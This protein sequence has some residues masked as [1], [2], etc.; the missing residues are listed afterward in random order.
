MTKRRPR[1][2]GPH[3]QP[4]V[5]RYSEGNPVRSMRWPPNT[6]AVLGDLQVQHHHK[7]KVNRIAKVAVEWGLAFLETLSPQLRSR[8][9]GVKG[10]RP[11]TFEEQQRLRVELE[12]K[13]GN[14]AGTFRLNDR[15]AFALP[16]PAK[17]LIRQEAQRSHVSMSVIA[18]RRIILQEAT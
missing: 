17:Q 18:R 3:P 10:E 15:L 8:I 9:L 14:L 1:A 12:T 4:N 13:L 6:W 16:A 7:V 2:K 11:L 5:L